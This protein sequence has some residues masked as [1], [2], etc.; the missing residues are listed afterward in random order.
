MEAKSLKQLK[1]ENA[2]SE[3]ETTTPPQ[4]VK[5]ETE[6]E[7]AEETL[8]TTEEDDAEDLEEESDDKPA[9][10][11]MQGDEED[12]E[13]D[14]PNAAWKAAR[15]KY[16]AKLEKHKEESNEELSRLRAENERL[17]QG[18]QAAPVQGV[19]PRP[20]RADFE[21]SDDPDGAYIDAL[22]DWKVDQNNA[23]QQASQATAATQQ[24]QTQF[25]QEV[26]KAVDQHCERAAQL[27]EKS[28]IAPDTYRSAE[29]RVRQM[30]DGLF[31]SGGD[32]ITDGLIAT[33]GE[34]S[35][36][37]FYNLGVNSSRLAKLQG[38]LMEDKNGLKAATYLGKLSEQLS[39]PQKRK[40]KAPKPAPKVEGDK[41]SADQFASL[42]RKWKAA[43]E[44]GDTSA[45]FKIRR[46]AK[47]AGA[48]VTNW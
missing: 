41:G 39:S 47:K 4:A 17:K 3:E 32:V 23:K 6:D 11:W 1:A 24:R 29:L 25:Q 30:I 46:E 26:E 44:K 16:K 2:E 43:H 8:E 45:A 21:E 19:K 5:D 13:E 34:G 48:K 12:A 9:E 42:K 35:E 22:T 40:T 33:L 36:K 20:K 7:A 27:A 18:S 15:T 28:G 38:L 31:P 14:I 10:A 37:V